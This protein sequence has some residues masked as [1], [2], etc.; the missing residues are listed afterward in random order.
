MWERKKDTLFL[1]SK[2][3][4]ERQDALVI[5]ESGNAAGLGQKMVKNRREK[6]KARISLGRTLEGSVV[7]FIRRSCN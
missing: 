6:S 1:F 4:N 5:Y 7:R 3:K 2:K